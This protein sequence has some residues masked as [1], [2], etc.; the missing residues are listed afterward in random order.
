MIVMGKS[1]VTFSNGIQ[2]SLVYKYNYLLSILSNIIALCVYLVFWPSVFKFGVGGDKLFDYS[3]RSIM[4]Y[5]ILAYL[6]KQVI[7]STSFG[8]RVK[9]D[10]SSGKL[11][12][13]LIKPFSYLWS[14]F[15]SNIASQ[16]I[17]VI[18]SVIIFIIY[19]YFAS[20]GS[21]VEYGVVQL[22]LFLLSIIFA[23]ILSNLVSLIVGLIAFWTIE[24]NSFGFLISGLTM[25]L[26]GA[27]FPLDFIS[28]YIYTII[29]LLPFRFMIFFPIQI[30]T[31]KIGSF[32]LI[33]GFLVEFIWCIILLNLVDYIWSHGLKRYAAYG[34]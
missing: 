25:L 18:V 2:Q 6:L 24:T 28:S 16:F 17:V 31:G 19:T 22:L 21:L 14:A 30:F 29:K 4:S 8:V 23:Y 34:G 1:A 27:V 33:S 11:S 3:L 20:I 5:Y 26:S 12:F 10:I 13:Y 15:I 7:L 9:M 32:E